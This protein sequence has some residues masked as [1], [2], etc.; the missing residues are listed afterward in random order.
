[1][2]RFICWFFSHRLISV[3][4]SEDETLECLACTRCRSQFALH[5][6][7]MWFGPWDYEDTEV[8]LMLGVK[9]DDPAPTPV[10]GSSEGER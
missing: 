8:M 1:M 10:R 9:K 3:L 4:K 5:H 6:Q 7:S 2:K